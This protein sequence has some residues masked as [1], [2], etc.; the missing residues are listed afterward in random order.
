MNI[1]VYSYLAAAIVYG[2][3]AVLLMLSW[4]SSMQGKLL[5]IVIIISAVWAALAA[6]I[7]VDDTGLI[8]FYQVF[9]LL[10][11]MA[12]YVFLLKLFEMAASQGKGGTSYKKIVRW[13]LPMCLGFTGLLLVNYWFSLSIQPVLG[14]AGQVFLA[15]IGLAI[16]EQLYRNTS[17]RY[18][19]ATKYLF[20]GVGGIFAFDFYFY[21]DALLFRRVDQGLWE[22]RGV[23]NLMAVP[24][25]AI[26]S[27]RNKNWSL[28]IFVS[29][30]VVF[31]T[32]A[33]MGG[34]VY[35][36]LMAGAG[37]YIR[38]FGGD[39]GRIGQAAFLSLA[40]VLLAAILFSGQ[41][42]ARLKVFLAKHFY[43]NKYDYRIEWLRLTDKLGDKVGREAQFETII[44]ALA[45]TIDA[46]TGLLWLRD[47][48]SGYKNV[49]SW[50]TGQI[51]I[52]EPAGSSL[53]HFFE[54]TG[55]IIN[56]ME[57]DERV[58]EYDG[59]N[60]PE[61]LQQINRP[62]QIIPLQEQGEL[63]GFV[64]L[65]DPLV[66]RTINW[67]DRDLLKT[68]AKQVSNH[69]TVLMTTD[70]LAEAKQFEVFS[71]LSAYMVHDLKNIAS[72]LEMVA[73]NAKRHKDNPEFIED[74][75]GTVDNAAGD[76]KKLLDQLRNKQAQAEKK[77]S[78]ELAELVAD[79]VRSK[80]GQSPR[81]ELD[82]QCS[83]SR[84]T[85][86]KE[87]LSNVL[88]H[89]I[90][91]AQQATDDDGT[92]EIT[93]SCDTSMYTIEIKDSGHGMT[94]DFIRDRLFKPFDTTKGNAG[95][96]IGMHESR[97]FIRGI[98]GD[99]RVQSKPEKGSIISLLL[100]VMDDGDRCS[101][102]DG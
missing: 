55:Y 13:I 9:E 68:A 40:V 56:L 92:I 23:V 30:E 67:E 15:L 62:W 1:G 8:P 102:A 10:R 59:L 38:A 64:I 61:W 101:G 19:W 12:W 100:P 74:A 95:M 79:V 77:T 22:I 44:S 27:A 11:Y 35:L 63:I 69:L 37:Y 18:R 5:F 83:E 25:L 42:R 26:S 78:F 33:I 46:R 94:A 84:L 47:G 41:V 39:W 3:F 21:A 16:I 98:G 72:E 2:F 45:H 76:I 86:E 4:R 93:V 7:A 73:R 70:A 88:G 85:V 43:K 24:L 31:N 99:I 6:K 96:G 87:R 54:E 89:L 58:D 66:I 80:S 82:V 49:A 17:A 60:L 48:G 71:R 57:I 29:R 36:L 52:D 51:A 32:T 28:N 75:F 81:P 65:A 14:I 34:G 90:D 53:V 97:D 91:N 50:N 20:L